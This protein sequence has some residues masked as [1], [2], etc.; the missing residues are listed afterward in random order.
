MQNLNIFF[1]IIA[2][3][4]VLA[5]PTFYNVATFHSVA[6]FYKLKIKY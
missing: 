1:D 6:Q 4:A 5:K 3:L 2:L